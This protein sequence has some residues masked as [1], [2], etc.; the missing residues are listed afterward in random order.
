MPAGKAPGPYC[1][2][3]NPQHIE[4]GTM[5]RAPSPPPVPVGTATYAQSPDGVF[6]NRGT[7]CPASQRP[8]DSAIVNGILRAGTW[9]ELERWAQFALGPASFNLGVCYGILENLAGSVAGLVDLLRIFV[10]AG[11]YERVQHPSWIPTDV[12][13]YLT[14]KAA[15]LVLGGKLKQAHDQCEALMREL[16]YAVTHPRELFGSIKNQYAAKWKRFE[17]LVVDVSLSSQFE[18]GKIA[19]EVLLDVLMLIGVGE[20]AL[21]F[22]AKLPELAKLAGELGDALKLGSRAAR[23]AGAAVEEAGAAEGAN[24]AASARQEARLLKTTTADAP[25][26]ADGDAARPAVPTDRFAQLAER[27]KALGLPPAGDAQDAATLSRLEINGKSF[28][29]I[30]SG[31]QDPKT[32]ITLER[33]NAQTK[34]HAEA[35]AVQKAINSGMKG[36]SSQAEMWIDR[37][38]CAACGESGGLR[39]LARNLGVDELVVHS[40]SGTQTFTP[41]Q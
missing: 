41:T 3:N 29:G 39:S 25:A 33:V 36:T 13:A 1:A 2:H 38:P 19:G 10:L 7:A 40:P 16:K 35:E 15:E 11:L 22:A 14:A 32:P 12:P 37:D 27:R 30:N 6:S 8:S 31:L 28:D 26:G 4:D 18:A 9:S 34:T 5:C 24:A 21:K 17:T 20:A 23:G